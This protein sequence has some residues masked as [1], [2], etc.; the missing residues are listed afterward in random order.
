MTRQNISMS[1]Y[2]CTTRTNWWC[3]TCQLTWICNTL[4]PPN[5]PQVRKKGYRMQFSSRVGRGIILEEL[6]TWCLFWGDDGDDQAV[7][8][9][10]L[11][12]GEGGWEMSDQLEVSSLNFSLLKNVW[13]SSHLPDII[14]RT[15]KFIK[16]NNLQSPSAQKNDIQRGF[17]ETEVLF[18]I[19]QGKSA[20]NRS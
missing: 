11:L 16:P 12:A 6:L 1:K 10:M 17:G 4:P 18:L 3:H 7:M 20:E 2:Y 14:L 13:P 19:A 8:V 5:H 9:R 15:L